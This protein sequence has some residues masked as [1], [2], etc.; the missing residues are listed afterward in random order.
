MQMRE[1]KPID[2][3]LRR[4]LDEQA[5]AL[6][7]S[8]EMTDE[9]RTRMLRQRMVRALESRTSIPGL[10][11]QV[12]MCQ[13][14]IAA[15]LPARLYLP[16]RPEEPLPLLVY[17]HGG[18][19][20]AGSVATHDPFCRLLSEAAQVVIA[21]IEYRMAPE[22]PYP[23][24][25][26]DTL[27]A[28]QWAHQH[29]GECGGDVTRLALGG[30]SAGANLAAVVA[31][32]LC[33][34]AGNLPLRALLLLYPVTDSPQACHPSYIENATGYGLEAK[35]MRW[36]WRQYAPGVSPADPDVS[37]LQ[38]HKV[39]AL[40]PTLV[41]TAEY[42]VLRDEGL[43]YAQKLAAAG[44]AVTRQHAPDM[45]HNFPVHPATVARFPQCDAAL[46]HIAAWLRAT[47]ARD[48]EKGPPF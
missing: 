40:P 45:H 2:P 37:P 39:P 44:V 18:G 14:E 10:P 24:A 19:W 28:V 12:E 8:V 16:P 22:H 33:A 6:G 21:S 42:D 30:D 20:V 11:N 34:T 38:L 35:L 1:R 47:L 43:A 25:V 46:T 4:F 36:F 7:P 29:A 9:A 48:A 23:A 32:R 5:A 13:V 41:T 15:G 31:N 27:A 17:L 3:E 26:D